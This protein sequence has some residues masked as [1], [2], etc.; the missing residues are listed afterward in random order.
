MHQDRVMAGDFVRVAEVVAADK[1][2]EVLR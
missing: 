2:V 1:L